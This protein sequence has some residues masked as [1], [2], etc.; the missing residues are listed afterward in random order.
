MSIANCCFI[1]IIILYQNETFARI[2]VHLLKFI[3]GIPEYHQ[4]NLR[5]I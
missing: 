3:A 4:F 5:L 1:K 2:S